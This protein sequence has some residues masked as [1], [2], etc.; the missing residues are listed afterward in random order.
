MTGGDPTVGRMG[1]WLL[2]ASLA[3]LFAAA[4]VGYLIIRLRAPEWP[5]S[6][7]PSL[8]TGIWISTGLLVVLSALLWRAEKSVAGDSGSRAT[9]LM[10]ASALVATAFLTVQVGNWMQLAA[11]SVE[12]KPDLLVWGFYVLTFLHAVHVLAGIPPLILVALRVRRGAYGPGNSEGIHLVGMYWH[13]LLVTWVVIL[14][15]LVV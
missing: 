14:V 11:D 10:V 15:V 1:M 8:P 7:S 4:I 12:P 2:L 13:F 3:V 5:P 9:R 6:G